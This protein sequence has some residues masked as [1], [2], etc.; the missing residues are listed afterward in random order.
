VFFDGQTR[1][2]FQQ[3]LPAQQ[4]SKWNESLTLL[5]EGIVALSLEVLFISEEINILYLL[6]N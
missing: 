4:T 2:E 3:A 1:S 6:Y 5:S